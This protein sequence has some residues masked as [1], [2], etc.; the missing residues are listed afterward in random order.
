MFRVA[1]PV[2]DDAR[3]NLGLLKGGIISDKFNGT[4]RDCEPTK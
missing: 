4:S 1:Y 3:E 2:L